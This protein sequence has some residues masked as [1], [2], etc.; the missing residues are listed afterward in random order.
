MSIR[1]S[2]VFL[3]L[4]C[5]VPVAGAAEKIHLRADLWMPFTGDPAGE[6]PGYAVEIARDIFIPQGILV[7]YQIMPWGDALRA[8]KA[9]RIDGVIGANHDE[10]VRLVT[11]AEAVGEARVGIFVLKTSTWKYD[12][13]GS[14]AKIRLG[15]QLAYKYWDELDAYIAS[16][17]EPQVIRIGGDNPIGAAI[18]QLKTGAIDALPETA[19]VF[20]WAVSD[21]GYDM[22]DFRAA[23]LRN[24]EMVFVAFAPDGERGARYARIFDLGLQKLRQS[25]ELDKILRRYGLTDWKQ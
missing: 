18:D 1:A 20:A 22:S 13:I 9:G 6:K 2:A 10:A 19:P 11:P 8:A 14:L 21:A 4:L 16:H 25:G 24:S 3:L 7:D 23:H 15:V 17:H 5:L 12:D